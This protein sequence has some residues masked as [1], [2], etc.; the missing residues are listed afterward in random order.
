M[1]RKNIPTIFW[2]KE[3]PNDF[4]VFIEAAKHFEYVFTPDTNCIQKH[5]NILGHDKVY[6][7]PLGVQ[8]KIHNPINKDKEKLGEVAFAGSWYEKFDK[9]KNT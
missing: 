7:L 2:A 3:D 4:N 9:R 8:P 6:F 1:Q 5:K